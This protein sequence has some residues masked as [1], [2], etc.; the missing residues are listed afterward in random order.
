[1]FR[2][3]HWLKLDR[4]KPQVS[5]GE[6]TGRLVEPD[7]PLLAVSGDDGRRLAM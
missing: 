5:V 6:P 7:D 2:S 4:S 3:S 1:V